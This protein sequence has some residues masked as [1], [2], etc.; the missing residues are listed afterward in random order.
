MQSHVA[1]I[2]LTVECILQLRFSAESALAA[3]PTAQSNALRIDLGIVEESIK[4]GVTAKRAKAMDKHLSHW[5]AFCVAHNV[6][7]FL[8]TWADPVPIL[9]VFGEIYQDGRLAPRKKTV[10]ARTV[11]DGLR[12]FGQVHAR[13]GGPDPR[14]DSHGGIDFL[15]QRQI[16]AYT[17]EDSPP[18]R[19]NQC[20]SSSSFSLWQKR[21]EIPV[22]TLKWYVRT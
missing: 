4:Q 13:L 20:P 21:S 15:I 9:Q 6:D 5:Y 19:V 1:S 7:P 22:L 17:K 18:R 3:L 12:A 2:G 14:K 11:E 8:K 10:R 16:K